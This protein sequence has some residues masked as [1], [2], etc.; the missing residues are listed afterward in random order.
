MLNLQFNQSLNYILKRSESAK[1]HLHC[2]S[3]KGW[4]KRFPQSYKWVLYMRTGFFVWNFCL[5]K[6]LGGVRERKVLSENNQRVLEVFLVPNT[7]CTVV[8]TIK[9]KRIFQWVSG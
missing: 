5:K 4:L 1:L 6:F 3:Q 7:M 2:G 9:G 8:C